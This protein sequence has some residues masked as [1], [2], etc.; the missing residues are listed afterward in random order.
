MEFA[1]HHRGFDDHATARIRYHAKRLSNATGFENDD[2]E[3]IAQD[4]A[5]DLLRRLPRFD[6]ARA[7]LRTFIARVVKNCAET[8]REHAL[9]EKRGGAVVHRS[10]Y[11]L[12]VSADGDA[13]CP[14]IDTLDTSV[15]LWADLGTPWDVR[16]DIRVD[17]SRA[18][19]RLPRP[20]AELAGRLMNETVLEIS[21]STGQ[22]RGAI[23]DAIHRLREAFREAGLDI[24]LHPTPT[25]AI[26]AR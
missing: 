6:P 2:A 25:S 24:Y 21:R 14:L 23:Y 26:A 4:L 12:T 22:S 5:L 9:V 17:V 10:L 1:G 19:S 7:G 16:S 15:G 13:V 20:L 8:R 18:V 3:D 11:D